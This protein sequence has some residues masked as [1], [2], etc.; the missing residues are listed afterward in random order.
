M[1]QKLVHLPVVHEAPVKSTGWG[2]EGTSGHSSWPA[3]KG[4]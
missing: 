2:V 4:V 1:S 3:A